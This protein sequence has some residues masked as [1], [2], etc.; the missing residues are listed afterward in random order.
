VRTLRLFVASGIYSYRALFGWVSPPAYVA[1][2]LAVPLLQ[3]LFFAWLGRYTGTAD[4][5]FFLVGNATQTS[6]MAGI[7]AMAQTISGERMA[8]TLSTLLVTPANRV[9]MLLGRAVPVVV[10]ALVV[11]AAGFVLGG[12]LLDVHLGSAD[13][14]AVAVAVAVTVTSTVGLGILVGAVG[15]LARDV[16][17]LSNVVYLLLLAVCGANVP[18]DLLPGWVARFAR[19]LPLTH[20]LEAVRG[21]VRGTHLGESLPALATEAGVGLAYAVAG[22]ACFLAMAALGRRGGAFEQF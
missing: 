7:H 11:S 14:P 12:L 3:V 15:L 16:S 9:V 10:N 20:G 21:A 19:A 8:G 13:T 6:A 1:S 2:M 22:C 18:L 5:T 17:F 4:D